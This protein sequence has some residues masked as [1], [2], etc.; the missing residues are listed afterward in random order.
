MPV[1]RKRYPTRRGL[2][3]FF[4]TF[5]RDSTKV[6]VFSNTVLGIYQRYAGGNGG[7]RARGENTREGE[8]SEPSFADY[9]TGMF[10][11][12]E[13]LQKQIKTV[14]EPS[15]QLVLPSSKVPAVHLADI[16]EC[17]V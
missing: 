10:G 13:G 4:G 5:A 7:R 16:A 11:T 3:G 1:Y 12:L 2:S 8:I 15:I 14:M 17:S 9:F 6:C